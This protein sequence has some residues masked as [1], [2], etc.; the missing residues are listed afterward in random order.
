MF[1]SRRSVRG[2]FAT[3]SILNIKTGCTKIQRS[4][5]IVC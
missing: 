4:I 3:S 2:W 1:I 5:V